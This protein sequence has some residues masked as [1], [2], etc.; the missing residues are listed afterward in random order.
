MARHS[1]PPMSIDS[2]VMHADIVATIVGDKNVVVTGIT[3]DSRNVEPGDILC[4]VRGESFDG[5]QFIGEAISRGA[6]A[7][8]VDHID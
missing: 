8:L 1:V 5:H 6:V 7:V 4:C 2:L 3:Q